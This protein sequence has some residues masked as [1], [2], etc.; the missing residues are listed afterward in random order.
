MHLAAPRGRNRSGAFPSLTAAGSCC[1]LGLGAAAIGLWSA[2]AV[3]DS[4]T[5]RCAEGQPLSSILGLA[6]TTKPTA[7]GMPQG[8]G[9]R[10]CRL[11]Q[12]C[13]GEGRGGLCRGVRTPGPGVRVWVPLPGTT[14]PNVRCHSTCRREAVFV[15]RLVEGS[16]APSSVEGQS[17]PQSVRPPSPPAQ[18]ALL[19]TRRCSPPP[20]TK[21]GVSDYLPARLF[22]LVAACLPDGLTD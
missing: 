5:Q 3:A 12:K 18:C 14:D 2:G 8:G 10:S 20:K 21:P 1:S 9:G 11:G 17:C 4:R 16:G 6:P 7:G 22:D 13:R 19:I 15:C